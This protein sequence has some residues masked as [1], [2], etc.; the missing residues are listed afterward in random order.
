MRPVTGGPNPTN[1]S[2]PLPTPPDNVEMENVAGPSTS[3]TASVG[4]TRSRKSPL[5]T[6]EGRGTATYAYRAAPSRERSSPVDPTSI[7]EFSSAAHSAI[8]PFPVP[9]TSR[10]QLPGRN[11]ALPSGGLSEARNCSETSE[12][13]PS[14]QAE[15]E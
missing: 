9:S 13:P 7:T 11:A 5:T 2:E 1:S 8:P 4:L 3:A 6:E 12:G 10:Q 15:V 14:Q